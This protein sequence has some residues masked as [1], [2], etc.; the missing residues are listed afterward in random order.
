MSFWDK[1]MGRG[2]KPADDQSGGNTMGS[3][4]MQQEQEGM[5]PPSTEAPAEPEQPAE[6][7]DS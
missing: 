7:S 5:A 6:R 2:K 3:D 1:I 4:G